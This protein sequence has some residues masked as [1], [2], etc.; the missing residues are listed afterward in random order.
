MDDKK[1]QSALQ[2]AL[3]SE[4]QPGNVHLWSRVREGLFAGTTPQR[5]NMKPNK[6]RV[7]LAA[8]AMSFLL[9]FV[10]ITPQGRALAQRMFQFF[11]VTEEKSFPIP[12]DQVFGVPATPTSPP[13]QIL[14]I[15]PALA[16]QPKMTITPDAACSSTASRA[17]YACQVK[18]VESQA[19][20]DAREFQFDP[21]GMKFIAATYI[22]ATGEINME[23]D[24]ITGGGYLYLRQGISDFPDQVGLWGKVPSDAVDE[25]SVNGLYAEIA[26]GTY[27]V[28]PY[29]TSAVWEP[30]GQLSLA[31]RDGSHWFV[32]EK[33]GDPYPIEWIT[34][35][36]LIKLA[37]GL[38]NER[39]VNAVPP[40]DPDYLTLE[41]A[42]TL[43]GF[44]IPTPALL[45]AGFEFKRAAWVDN[46]VHLMY[47]AKES[48]Q[49][50]LFIALGPITDN[51]AGPCTECPPGAT[52]IVQVG[53]WQ[54]W[55]VRGS[56][57]TFYA[58]E[59]QPTQTPIW[60]G[61][62]LVWSLSWNTD[63]YWFTMSYIPGYNSGRETDKESLIEIAESI[64]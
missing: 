23:F 5:K 44:D 20:F 22:P 33:L 39:D 13:T 24:V 21:K 14:P 42:E 19:G 40:L 1:I 25:V 64:K 35:D 58:A 2:D 27:V 26:L 8:L 31:W 47:G 7:T 59:G 55:Y 3:E 54:G 52:E 45:P 16:S 30:G 46:S 48:S 4:I 51:Q 60:H 34:P 12:T 53:P 9:A 43:A 11:T 36:Q 29:A 49:S 38:V 57:E 32:I 6:R 18:A 62:A 63:T 10:L 15:E 41:Q 17:T 50:D 61:D 28:Y 56:N 37:E